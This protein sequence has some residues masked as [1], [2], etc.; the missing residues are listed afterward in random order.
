MEDKILIRFGELSTKG[1]NKM[2][3]VRHLGRNIEKLVGAKVEVQFDRIFI[4]YSKENMERL[5]YVFG[6]HS[7]SRVIVS[8]HDQKEVEQKSL[9]LIKDNKA[10]TFKVATKRHWKEY[11]T[12]SSEYNGKMGAFILKNSSMKV[13]VKNPDLKVE[14]EIRREGIYIFGQRVEGLGGYPT[15]I[16]G[17]V[18]HLMSGGID[19][20]VAAFLLMKRGMHVD[21][22]NFITPPHTDEKT[23]EKVERIVKLLTKYQ[24]SSTLYRSTYTDLLH[25]IAMVSKASYRITLMRRSFYRIANAIADKNNYLLISNGDNLGQ[26]AS[27]T[28]ESLNVIGRVSKIQIMRPLL[29]NDKLETINFA[30][31]L[32]TYQ[33]SIEKA[34]DSCELFAPESPVI[35]PTFKEVEKLEDELSDLSELEKKN[36]EEQIEVL[37]FEHKI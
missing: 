10:K 32:G 20:P 9:L 15:G 3:F 24:G 27:Q 28:P 22:L 23:N 4:N 30:E 19:S 36:I 2:S 7:Y 21:Y 26:V 17:K 29:T 18:L 12:S 16:N 31:K 25:H 37:K 33:I 13:D 5:Q 8:S 14:Y 35:K 6:I 1:K 11:T 34:S